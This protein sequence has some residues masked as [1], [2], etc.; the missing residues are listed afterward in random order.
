MMDRRGPDLA[1][2]S[3]PVRFLTPISSLA[4]LLA[5]PRPFESVC[6]ALRPN[7]FVELGRHTNSYSAFC[8]GVKHSG[9]N[10]ACFAVDTSGGRPARRLLRRRG[11]PHLRSLPRPEIREILAAP[12]HDFRRRRRAFLRRCHRPVHMDGLH[13]YDAVG[14]DSDVAASGP[15]GCGAVPRHQRAQGRFRG[16]AAVGGAGGD[17][18]PFRLPAF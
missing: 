16:V 15:P 8:Q 14:H 9:Q 1:C 11:L 2:L 7:I 12:A 5:G 6:K 17:A 10:T 3:R 18:P 4:T 13:T